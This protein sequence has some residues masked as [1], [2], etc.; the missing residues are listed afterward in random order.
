MDAHD[1][2]SPPLH[3]EEVRPHTE[4]HIDSSDFVGQ[5]PTVPDYFVQLRDY[6]DEKFTKL[7]EYVDERFTK[8]EKKFED[9]STEVKTRKKT[10]AKTSFQET[11]ILPKA[12]RQKMFD[13]KCVNEEVMPSE[14]STSSQNRHSMIQPSNHILRTPQCIIGD[15]GASNAQAVGDENN[16]GDKKAYNDVLL[17]YVRSKRQIKKSSY[18]SSP[19]MKL[20]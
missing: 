6:V 17:T 16:N 1:E 10:P 19:F 14:G 3:R 12:N 9:I 7:Q 11:S 8:I 13:I 4:T 20:L 15:E 18:L 2:Q 5:V